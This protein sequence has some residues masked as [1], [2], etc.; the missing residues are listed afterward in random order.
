MTVEERARNFA[1]ELRALIKWSN[2]ES[3]KVYNRLKSEGATLGLD[4]H[5]EEF[6][7]IREESFRRYRE[8]IEKYK[9]LPPGT[10]LKLW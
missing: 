5:P 1:A 9:D 4:S 10:K 2:E 6:A 3:E 7:P 8:I